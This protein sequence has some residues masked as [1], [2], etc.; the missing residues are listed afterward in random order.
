MPQR[1]RK[2]GKASRDSCTMPFHVTTSGALA[3]G[4]YSFA[5]QPASFPRVQLE[6]DVWAH[7]RVRK[8]SFRQ[9]P[10]SP[11]TVGQIAGYVGGIED[12]PPATAVQVSEL[13]PSCSKGVGQTTPT[14]WV[15]VPR[16]DL[17]GPFPWYKSQPGTA[18]PTEESPGQIVV[19]GT[20]TEAYILEIKGVFEFKTSVNS[21]NT[22]LSLKLRAMIR[23]ERLAYV[24]EKERL[25]LL[26]VLKT[27]PEQKL[28]PPKSSAVSADFAY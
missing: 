25:A 10:T 6:A 22:P 27:P 17:A 14:N 8:L 16:A 5:V 19:V 13:L 26:R 12:T 21:G 15:H 28:P 7:F 2:G 4:V 18:D 1:R 23:E 3:A 9:L 20:G 24:R 11:I